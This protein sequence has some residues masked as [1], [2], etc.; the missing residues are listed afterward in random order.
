MRLCLPLVLLSALLTCFVSPSWSAYTL[1]AN[2]EP[3]VSFADDQYAI[4][5]PEGEP[6]T[7][8]GAWVKAVDGRLV[9]VEQ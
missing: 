7:R 3:T 4:T 6:V 1:T 5:P 8:A 2:G 9:A